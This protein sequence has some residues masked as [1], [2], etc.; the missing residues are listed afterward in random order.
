LYGNLI[1]I[2]NVIES[3]PKRK[4]SALA[5]LANTRTQRDNAAKE[6]D[7]P[8]AQESALAEKQNRLAELNSMLNMD[9]AHSEH[10]DM[11]TDEREEEEDSIKRIRPEPEEELER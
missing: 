2:D 11:E 7:K 10:M 1:R 4:D 8:F 6:I 3:I 5:Q 9:D